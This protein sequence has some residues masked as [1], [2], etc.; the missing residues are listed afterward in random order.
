MILPSLVILDA[1]VELTTPLTFT[2]RP[3]LVPFMVIEFAYIP[4]IA[5]TSNPIL[6]ESP[7]F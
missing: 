3:V 4:P 6:L 5:E 7:I 2:P 1:C